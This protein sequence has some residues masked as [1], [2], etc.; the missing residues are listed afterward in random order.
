MKHKEALQFLTGEAALFTGNSLV[1]ADLHLGIEHEYYRKGITLPSQTKRL[2]E[3][4][5]R[6]IATTKAHKLVILGDVKHKV[7]G[8]SFQEER[9]IPDFFDCF[10]KK[11]EVEILPGNHDADLPQ[12]V[13]KLKLRPSKGVLEGNCYFSHGHTWPAKKFLNA[14]YVI[15]GHDHPAVEFRDTLGFRWLEPVWVRAAFRKKRVMEKYKLKARP[16]KL[17]ELIIMPAFN[18]FSGAIP[19]N[20]SVTQKRAG[21]EPGLGPLTKAADM[22]KAR[23]YL[24]DGTFLGQLKNL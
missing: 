21:A 14:E 12:L 8:T 22:K 1:I 19:L 5:D 23:I 7:P 9:E 15:M 16:P 13:K 24:L 6:L 4:I 20:T 10:L 3:R 17:P 2:Q 18:T 11:I